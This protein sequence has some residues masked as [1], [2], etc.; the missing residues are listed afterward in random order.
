[1]RSRFLPLIAAVAIV[2]RAAAADPSPS[3]F[4]L[5]DGSE[6]IMDA[7]LISPNGNVAPT[8]A[9]RLIDGSVQ[10]NGRK[11][12]RMRTW[13]DLGTA[14]NVATKLIRKDETGV[15]TIEQGGKD[16][17]EQ[18]EVVFPLGIGLTWQR[19]SHGGTLKDTVI[20]LETVTIGDTIYDNC[21]HLR[22]TT[23]DHKFSE[24]Y[25]EAPEVGSVKS[26][27]TFANGA[28][29]VLTLREFKPG[30]GSP[31]PAPQ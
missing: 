13:M 24:S 31:A 3:F 12:Y 10:V 22:T 17:T 16:A 1:M 7:K 25:W 11:Y 19:T 26:I 21:L 8:T 18:R 15:Y 5:I 20:A 27:M 4:P 2:G 14:K 23:P 29:I 9:H 30:P 28:K 6:W